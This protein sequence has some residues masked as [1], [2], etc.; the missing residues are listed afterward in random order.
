[1]L[2]AGLIANRIFHD[3]ARLPMFKYE[4]AIVTALMLLLAFGPLSV[5]VPRLAA[6]R[7]TGLREYGRL[8]SHYVDEFEQKWL[9]G[10]ATATDAT[11]RMATMMATT[12]ATPT[13]TA[14]PATSPP[15]PAGVSSAASVPPQRPRPCCGSADLQSLADL[16]NSF[17]VIREM[18]VVPFGRQTV[19]RLAVAVLLP[20]A[21]LV[22]TMIPLDE[23]L[24]RLVKM[25]L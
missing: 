4:I 21:P 11:T 18:Q 8:A 5:F 6:C 25:L 1:M 17:A 13:T 19:F 12:Q 22:L 3:G 16:G 15:A 9:H 23:L 7:R 20:L 10:D 2:L 24:S 14:T